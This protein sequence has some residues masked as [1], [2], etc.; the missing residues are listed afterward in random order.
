MQH[1]SVR[2]W[3]SQRVRTVGIGQPQAGQ[4][5]WVSGSS[6]QVQDPWASGSSGQVRTSGHRAAAVR[7]RSGGAVT[8]ASPGENV[9]KWTWLEPLVL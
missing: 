8:R 2:D 4:D 9:R 1:C 7:C 6:R 5:P 3:W